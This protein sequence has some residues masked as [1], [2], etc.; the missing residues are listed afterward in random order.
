ML[1][2]S[3]GRRDYTA[4]YLAASHS[5][6]LTLT[7]L[8][9]GPLVTVSTAVS[10][11]GRAAGSGDLVE[12]LL[13][14]VQVV[15]GAADAAVPDGGLVLGAVSTLDSQGLA[16]QRVLVGVAVGRVLVEER[17]ADGDHLVALAR[18]LAAGAH[19]GGEVG[20][21]AGEGLAG[22]GVGA[23]G[24]GGGA[25]GGGCGGAGGGSLVGGRRGLVGGRWSL[26][27]GDRC[28]VA[29]YRGDVGLS[30][31][32]GG[33]GSSAGGLLGLGG[34][35]WSSL[36][37]RLSGGLSDGRGS[38]VGGSLVGRRR[39]SGSRVGGLLDRDG[40]RLRAGSGL[41]LDSSG[42]GALLLL[43]VLAAVAVAVAVSLGSA[44][45]INPDSGGDGNCLD[46]GRDFSDPDK[47]ALAVVQRD[48]IAK[49]EESAGGEGYDF[50]VHVCGGWECF[51]RI[52]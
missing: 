50:G 25:V 31:G 27:A 1:S 19:A 52:V 39:R 47:V 17:Q 16:A 45:S 10:R 49:D 40:G 46:G 37:G 42:L 29:G 2:S 32:R 5:S 15:H 24:S 20:D 11:S 18:G 26:V 4:S 38:L 22:L 34:G 12:E 51:G 9:H 44:S 35:G 6:P 13:R 8:V 14:H 3:R 48:G 21:L 28:D 36:S 7:T 43:V 23:V 33:L 30:G 41:H